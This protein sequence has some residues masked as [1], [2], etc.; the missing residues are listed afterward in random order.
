MK[1]ENLASLK[2]HKLTQAQ[3]DNAFAEGRIDENALYLVPD[4]TQLASSVHCGIAE[5]TND[6]GNNGDIYI[7]YEE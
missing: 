3:Y 5:P 1:I 6:I 4:D 7:M 2:I